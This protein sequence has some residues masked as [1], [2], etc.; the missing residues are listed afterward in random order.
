MPKNDFLKD[1]FIVDAARTA[2]GSTFK[3]LK[4]FSPSQ[5]AAI[6]VQGLLKHSKVDKGI[7]DQVIFGNTV[8]AGTGQ[9]LSRHAAFLAGLPV[10]VPA[11]TLN[12]VCG[13]G[14]QSII[15]GAQTIGCNE[16][17]II[18]AGGTESSSQSPYLVKK[19]DKEKKENNLT[20]SLIFDGLTCQ[21]TTK[22]MGDLAETVAGK[23]NISRNKQDQYAFASHQ[24]ACRAQDQGKFKQEIIPVDLGSG[25]ILSVDQRPRRSLDLEKLTNLPPV[26]KENGTVTA[27]NSSIPSDGSAAV[28]LASKAAV[29]KHKLTPKA[30]IL[31]YSSLAVE[32]EMVFTA[33]IPA[34]KEC[35][36][37][38]GLALKDIDLLE[39]SEAFAVQALLTQ[40]ELK[41]PGEK[42]NIFG[43]DV[44]LGHPLGA[45]GT[46][47]LV[48]LMHALTDCKKTKG[49]ASVCLGG[50]GAVAVAIEILS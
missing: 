1:I 7:V 17:D 9:N 36:K 28:L 34:V 24:K 8:S 50:G 25:G 44:A 13:S 21:L 35:L 38:C 43:G 46:R 6:T 45:A 12:N 11:F 49:I 30:R 27:G 16:A 22:R 18:I 33:S 41:I 10:S 23:F 20:D 14:L 4:E 29:K 2:V 26:F 48:T 42:M 32:P 47:I 5:L 37:K 31:G 3:A 19:S 40:Q 39:I 15:V